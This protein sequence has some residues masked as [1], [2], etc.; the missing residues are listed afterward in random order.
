MGIYQRIAW[1]A[2]ICLSTVGC[3]QVTKALAAE[4]LPRGE[5]FA[6]FG[7]TLRVGY[8]ENTGAFLG[9]GSGLAPELRF[10][11]FVV[12]A[13]VMLGGLVVYL[14]LS[15]GLDRLT[16]IG[17]S[18]LLSGGLSNVYDRVVNDGAVVDFINLGLGSVR[19]GIFNIADVAIMAGLAILVFY[20]P[21]GGEAASS[22]AAS[23]G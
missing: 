4:Y 12:G 17:F 18:L 5:M 20:R 14:V 13:S 9:L 8:T 6:F 19:T 16:L 11:I 23:Q 22:D 7:D 2:G 21:S 15:K 10:W 1:I 3:D